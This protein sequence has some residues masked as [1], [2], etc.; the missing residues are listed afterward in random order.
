MATGQLLPNLIARLAANPPAWA[1]QKRSV[2]P[3]INLIKVFSV[4]WSGMYRVR[5]ST[6]VAGTPDVMVSRLVVLF[7]E[8]SKYPV[9]SLF[10]NA[11]GTYDFTYVGRGPWSIVSYDHT[12]EYNAV[13][14]SNIIG[15]RM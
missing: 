5:G 11:D 10:S 9:R 12:G 7:D 1:T 4:V 6:A 13:I 15:N 8:R 3:V 2:M 14:S